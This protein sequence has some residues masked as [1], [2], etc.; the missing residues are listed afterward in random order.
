ML[1]K[2]WHGLLCT[3]HLSLIELGHDLMLLGKE[4]SGLIRYFLMATKIRCF[5]IS[6]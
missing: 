6:V 1:L 2:C 5:C 4:I 3:I